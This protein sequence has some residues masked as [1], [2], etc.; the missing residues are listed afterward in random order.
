MK[1][2]PSLIP[3]ISGPKI[4]PS[5]FQSQTEGLRKH[6]AKG[7][8][9]FREW[10]GRQTRIDL[11]EQAAKE[12]NQMLVLSASPAV[13][14]NNTACSYHLKNLKEAEGFLKL[15]IR[16]FPDIALS[17]LYLGEVLTEQNKYAEAKE[18]LDKVGGVVSGAAFSKEI[19]SARLGLQPL[20]SAIPEFRLFSDSQ[21]ALEEFLDVIVSADQEQAWSLRKSGGLVDLGEQYVSNGSGGNLLLAER[22]FSKELDKN[23]RSAAASF[24]L[25]RVFD[26]RKMHEDAI[27]FYRR[28]IECNPKSQ[29]IL[30]V[31]LAGDLITLERYDEALEAATK[32]IA[33]NPVVKEL[34]YTRA[35]LYRREAERLEGQGLKEKSIEYYVLAKKDLESGLKYHEGLGDD[36]WKFILE[37]MLQDIEARLEKKKNP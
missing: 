19:G 12:F 15:L 8:K 25:A 35:V 22:A 24:G 33:Q 29:P 36:Q 30:W 21:K 32:G 2:K 3:T 7:E 1:G 10:E 9:L 17:Y 16:K 34:F 20:V 28:S 26:L 23:P 27:K 4:D 13:L 11:L 14:F 18:I 37:L 6:F 31:K 5:S